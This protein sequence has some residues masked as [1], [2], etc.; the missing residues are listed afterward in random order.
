MDWLVRK[1]SGKVLSYRK[2]RIENAID[3][4]LKASSTEGS[5]REMA[6]QVEASLYMSFFKPGSIPTIEQIQNFIEETLMLR[7]HTAAARSFILYREKRSEARDVTAIFKGMDSL[8][9]DYIGRQDWRVNENSNMNYSL[10]GLNFYLS[11]SITSRY[12]LSK[13]YT[14]Q[15]KEFQDSGDMH[16]HDLGVLGPYCVG[17][18]LMELLQGGFLGARGKIESK[19]ASHL[20][21]A[22]GQIVNF[23]YTLQ[24]EAAG[25]QAFSNFDTLLAP[26]IRYDN[27]SYEQVIQCMQEFLFNINVPTRVGF[28]TPFTNITMDLRVPSTHKD[29]HVI[30]GGEEKPEKYGDFQNEMNILNRAFCELMMKGDAKGRIFTFPI[31]T[32]NITKDFDWENDNLQPLW[33]MTG[34]YGIPYFSNF[35]NSDMSPEDSRSMCCRLRLDNRELKARGGG[36]FGSNPLTGSIGVVTINIPRIAMVTAGDRVAFFQRLGSVMESARE[37]LELKRKFVEELTN[38]GL[39]PYTRYYLRHVKEEAGTFWANHFS[40]IGLIGMNEGA[41]NFMGSG[42]A[43]P[44]GKQWSLEV[45][46][47]MRDKLTEFQIETDHLYNLEASPA[48]S[49]S[50]SLAKKDLKEFPDAAHQGL[51]NPYYSNSVHLPV[52]THM[53]VYNLL[54]HQDELQTRFTGGTVVHLFIGEAI[55]DW[56]MVRTLARKIVNNFKLPYFSFT[57][58]FSICPVHGYISGE[59]FQCPYPHTDEEIEKYGEIVE[60]YKT[61]PEN[62]FREVSIDQNMKEQ[63]SLFLNIDKVDIK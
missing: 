62:S 40:T 49:A 37:S 44:E 56:R 18:D 50:Y 28:Q 13:I 54:K 47:F 35:V 57:P 60:I 41:L 24:G 21:T 15:I 25:A 14:P 45:L 43:T 16:I 51:S 38:R 17:W 10:Q 19:P 33:E 31:P 39:Y 3:R 23:F 36:L 2:S 5:S 53:D 48:E 30:V 8:V 6:D 58:T 20:R 29:L 12:W 26:F 1:R 52:N 46:D 55:T 34:K 61:L 63:P 22:L 59:H 27:L 32:Y 42:I 7:K 11:S 9:A 4:A